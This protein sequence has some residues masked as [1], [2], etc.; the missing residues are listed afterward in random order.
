MHPDGY[1]SPPISPAR[2]RKQDETIVTGKI[3][4]VNPD[5][6]CLLSA[7]NLGDK[8]VLRTMSIDWLEAN[9]NHPFMGTTIID[10]VAGDTRTNETVRSYFIRMRGDTEWAS[11]AEAE[12]LSQ[13]F[14]RPIRIFTPIDPGRFRVKIILGADYGGHQL[15]SCTS[16]TISTHWS[17]YSP[18]MWSG[19]LS[20]TRPAT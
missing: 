16:R 1:T 12:A 9:P 18:Q 8:N 11:L 2:T 17:T 14:K 20:A 3:A 6:S 19:R 13:I 5:G 10:Y 15:T 4:R 7:T